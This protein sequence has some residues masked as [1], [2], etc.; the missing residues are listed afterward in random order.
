MRPFYA[1]VIVVCNGQQHSCTW[2][3]WQHDQGDLYWEVRS[4]AEVLF[5]GR[6]MKSRNFRVGKALKEWGKDCFQWMQEC[7][8]EDPSLHIISSLKSYVSLGVF[9]IPSI[10]RE[11]QSMST[12]GL[13]SLFLWGS[14]YKHGKAQ[15]NARACLEGLMQSCLP[16]IESSDVDVQGMSGPHQTKCQEDVRQG[17]CVHLRLLLSRLASEPQQH[18]FSRLM[19]W[20]A[21]LARSSYA[22][23]CRACSA[24][25]CQVL[26]CLTRSISQEWDSRSFPQDPVRNATLHRGLKRCRVVDED[27]RHELLRRSRN[28][29][30]SAQGIAA[31]AFTPGDAC[32]AR[33]MAQHELP[34]YMAAGWRHW[35]REDC[36]LSICQDASRLGQPQ[37]ETMLY[38]I[39]DGYTASWGAPMVPGTLKIMTEL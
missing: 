12:F 37:E 17:L 33:H 29:K 4:V 22:G 16:G 38:G 14:A 18:G 15:G 34:S 39:T 27:L 24:L 20:M 2:K 28:K 10:A 25:C 13:L 32:D 30:Q 11:T 1:P 5:A 8:G 31:A 36:V 35:D 3:A 7:L 19:A 21:I 23:G 26:K 9:D 6:N